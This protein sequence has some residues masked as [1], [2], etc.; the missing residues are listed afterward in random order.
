MELNGRFIGVPRGTLHNV[1]ITVLIP[2]ILIILAFKLEPRTRTKF[3]EL[4][5]ANFL[6]LVAHPIL[7]LFD[8]LGV[9]AFYPLSNQFYNFNDFAVRITI[10]TGTKAYIAGP[11]AISI[12]IFF[13]VIALVFYLE[14][15]VELMHKHHDNLRHALG[16]ALKEEEKEIEKEL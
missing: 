14:E 1:F 6:F 5:V 8:N 4:A 9:Q 13:V 16:L 7:D 11:Q 12:M 15:V 2:L 10:S 3:K